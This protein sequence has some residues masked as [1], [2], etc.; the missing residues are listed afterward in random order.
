M[1]QRVR[2]F[3]LLLFA[4]SLACATPPPNQR[5]EKLQPDEF[6]TIALIYN[7]ELETLEERAFYPICLSMPSGNS[8]KALL[9]Y[10]HRYGFALYDSH[11]CNPSFRNGDSPHGMEIEI[12]K[13]QH[14]SKGQLD[15]ETILGDNTIHVGEHFATLLRHGTYHFKQ[16]SEGEW[17]IAGYTK[18]FDYRD[19]KEDPCVPHAPASPVTSEK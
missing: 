4:G 12:R 14:G 7:N 1:K 9:R 15:V 18:T 5:Q 2:I 10:L 19:T 17:K 8:T 6:N 16:N 13:L 11:I 3:G